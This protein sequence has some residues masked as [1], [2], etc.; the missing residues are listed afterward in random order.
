MGYTHY[1]RV[2]TDPFD[3]LAWARLCADTKKL[4]QA[5][6]ERLCFGYYTPDKPPVADAEEIRFNGW[7]PGAYEDFLLVPGPVRFSFCKT[8]RQPYDQMVCAVLAAAANR[9]PAITVTSNGSPE[10]WAP[11]LA[12][13][14]R[15]LK[16]KLRCPVVADAPAI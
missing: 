7:G 5:S 16:R 2:E 4:F 12:W 11:A 1:W 15:V 14:S 3:D 13:A 8:N 9:S 10:E 6:P